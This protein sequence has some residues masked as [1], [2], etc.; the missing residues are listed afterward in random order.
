MMNSSNY[1]ITSKVYENVNT[2]I[3][4]GQAKESGQP[5]V[6]KTLRSDDP[7]HREIARLRHEYEL[8]KD[9]NIKGIVQPYALDKFG[10]GEALILEDFDGESLRVFLSART[11]AIKDFLSIA[12][13]LAETLGELHQKNIIH[14]DIKP[15]NIIINPATGQVKITDFSIASRLS[16]ENQTIND[17]NL[18]EGTLAYMSPEQTG[19]MN[20]SLDYRTDFY[21]LGVTFYEMLTGQLPYVATDA[22][23]LVHCH[24]AKN[25]LPPHGLSPQIPQVLSAIVMKLLAKTAEDR[26]QSAYGIKVDLE[27]CLKQLETT[28][29]VEDFTL[30]LHDISAKFQIPQKLYGR[31]QE[32]AVL[33]AA[34]DRV[35]SV[36][37][38]QESLPTPS[39][40]ELML[41]AGYSGIGKSALVNEIHK[42]VV[43]QR[44][45]FIAG[46]FD[47]FKRN[48][49]YTSLIQAF[50]AL[51]RQILTESETQVQVWRDQLITALSPNG[52]V[53]IDVIP[54]VELIIGAQP[55]VP[56]L[57]SSETQNRFNLVFQQ[58]L[59]VFVQKE[60]PLVLFLDDLQWADS[61]SLKL[62]QRLMTASEQQCLLLLGAYRDNE[63]NAT[64]PLTLALEE[65]QNTGTVVNTITLAPLAVN[66]V[67]QLVADTLHCNTAKSRPL[68]KLLLRKTEGNPFFLTQMLSSLYQENLLSYNVNSGDW[69]WTLEQIQ[70]VKSTDNVVELMV[71]KLQK[72]PDVTQN[73]LKLAAC[74]GSTFN[75]NLLAIVN[76]KALSTTAAELW[77]A[78]QTGLVLPLSDTYKLALIDPLKSDL[79]TGEDELDIS[80]QFLHDRVQQAAYFLI[81]EERK[82]ETHLKVGRLLLKSIK[83]AEREEKIF[84]L[85][86]QL[87]IG[88]DLMNHQA[89]RI[90]LAA[91]NLLA[92]RKAKAATAYEPA[93][94]YLITGLALLADDSWQN[95]Y[96]LT[97]ALYIET[98]EVEYLNTHF[99]RAEQLAEVVLEHTQD[100]LQKVKVYQT[101]I[102][103]NIAR[104]QMLNAIATSLQV[105]E[106]LGESLTQEA[107]K[108]IVVE[109]LIHLPEMTDPYKLAA[110]EILIT[111][112]TP[113]LNAKPDLIPAMSF[114]LVSLAMRHG[115]SSFA[116][117]GYALYGL[118][119]CGGLSR[120]EEGYRFGQLGLKLQEQFHAKELE[121]KVINIFNVFIR[122]WKEPAQTTINPLLAGI[123]AGLNTGDI[124]YACYNSTSYC[125]YLFFVGEPL[126]EVNQKQAKYIELLLSL[127]QEYQIYFTQIIRQLVLNL[128][129]EV[130]DCTCLVGKSFNELEMVPI[131]IETKMGT[132][133]FLTYLAKTILLYILKDYDQALAYAQKAAPYHGNMVG[134]MQFV[135]YNF[136]YSLS[137]L[138]VYESVGTE[139]KAQYLEKVNSNQIQLKQWAFHAPANY[140]HKYELV[141]AEKA[142]V[143]GQA[144]EAMSGYDYAI[145]AAKEQGYLHEEAIANEAA[146]NFYRSQGREEIAHLYLTKAYHSYVHWG[147]ITKVKALEKTY[148][149]LAARPTFD[150]PTIR[151]TTSKT[152]STVITGGLSALDLTTIV[153]A[154][155]AIAG[156]IVLSKLL[157]KLLTI[158][159]ENAGAQ[160]S[161]L[162]LERAGQLMVEATGSVEKDGITLWQPQLVSTN[163]QLPITVINYVARTQ[164]TLVL[165]DATQEE[166]FARDPYIAKTRSKSILCTPIVNKGKLIGLLYLENN[167]TTGAFTPERLEILKLLSSQAAISLENALLYSNLEV[168]TQDLQQANVQLADHS[169][170]LEQ[171]VEQRTLEL[172]AK[173][174]QLESTLDELKQTQ[175][176]LI[177]TEK[178]SSLGQLV[179]GVAHEINNPVNFIHGNLDHASRYT[180]DLLDLIQ[181][182]RQQYPHATPELQKLAEEMDLE[183]LIQDLP[184]ILNSMHVGADRIRQI[185]LSLRNFS[186]LD[187]SDMKSV[188][189]HEGIESTLLLLQH[190]LQRKGSSSIE[191][192]KEYGNLP[193]V[194]CYV[195]Q[196]NQVI[197]NILSNAID[198]LEIYNQQQTHK[199]LQKSEQP[200]PVFG[201]VRICTETLSNDW[202]RIRIIDN[203]PGM[204]EEVR[205][206]LFDPFFT[207]KPIG[208]GTG[209]GLSI[210]YQIVANKHRGHLQCESAPGQGAEF[211]VEIPVQQ[212]TKFS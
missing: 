53:I 158:V 142:R 133:L 168:V 114:T 181:R 52:Q 68:A 208:A 160:T 62:L 83:P 164:E 178:M 11:L 85:V 58:F 183:F 91:L 175:I 109:D 105:L 88:I 56:Q 157:D 198:A 180:H 131:F 106:M 18:L 107:P 152:A 203:G 117:M 26:Y 169:R 32:V 57:G 182:Y 156:E 42:P 50:Q 35:A 102:Y 97:S 188:N 116:A 93:L 193:L 3:Y 101:K 95:Q 149:N 187:E 48:I 25:A 165:N 69:Q 186:R 195:G 74:I 86:N 146:E 60:H 64:H 172:Q 54:E 115:N 126:G 71:S 76:E 15:Q 27:T 163:Q 129:D 151:L 96:E 138:A 161:C 154:S 196:L 173:N 23:E 212:K 194:E 199:L 177:Q 171:K 211:I 77:E 170:T 82:K 44:G 39:R 210:S 190:R 205:S 207:T 38:G 176:Q 201:I 99:E 41:V 33:L 191:V 34:F 166:K 59:N 119:L 153:K 197:M 10:A 108:E 167:L 14:K 185:V 111:L 123:Q 47:Q 20:R 135:E 31:E 136:Y 37:S 81:P 100:L 22:M 1:S 19:R 130:D 28:G 70:Q 125:N 110:M 2:V 29:V 113:C 16:R 4:R 45:Y 24:I 206:K 46:K 209:M 36:G 98:V 6:I 124:E 148:S 150:S 55:A 9:L 66:D 122:H 184:K 132:L 92:G 147:A 65:I 118:I 84:D 80:Y 189:I 13:Q 90:K 204:S 140:Q 174:G 5:V 112:L 17:L 30:G 104:N 162:I 43:R 134:F 192:V 127:K 103:F 61:A 159:M 200:Q 40:S 7:T 120:I 139:K 144:L 155:Q 73:V 8:S 143:L 67:N 72:L 87:N 94:K 78:L 12:I 202:V 79:S 21:S 89:E 49:P 179:A 145:K 137:L 63:V 75:L 141:E 128:L 51:I 121:A